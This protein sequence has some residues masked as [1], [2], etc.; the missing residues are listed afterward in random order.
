MFCEK[1]GAR[2]EKGELYCP[3][4]GAPVGN[5]SPGVFPAQMARRKLPGWLWLLGAALLTTLLLLGILALGAAGVYQGLQER[6]RLSRE[7]A[8]IHHDRGQLYLKQGEYELAQAEFEEALRRAPDYG[9]AQE[10][11]REVRGIAQTQPTPT[12]EAKSQ[13]SES[14]LQQARTFYAQ[15]EW[16]RAVEKLLLLRRL[17]PDLKQREVEKLLFSAY[18]SQGLQQVEV[19]RLEEAIQHFDAALEVRP[20]DPSAL[21]QK[22]MA[23]L[24]LAG[25]GAWGVDWTQVIE[26]FKA[27][28]R[29]DEDY[30]DVASRLYEAYRA[31]GDLYASEKAWCLA[32]AQYGRA[33]EVNPTE[34]IMAR[35]RGAA[36]R[37]AEAVAAESATPPSD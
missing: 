10:S 16:A 13:A 5:P 20:N 24:Y 23:R 25:I 28:Y 4:C 2:I 29:L 35:W 37:C 27:L 15:G 21:R 36:E 17:D 19:G 3:Q 6:A 34:A 8:V 26:S 14:F 9:P 1:C 7:A 30:M 31:Y 12:S 22:E 18:Y 32:Q 11:L 33:A